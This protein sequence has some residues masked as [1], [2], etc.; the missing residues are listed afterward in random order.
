MIQPLFENFKT[1]EGEHVHRRLDDGTETRS[2][3][4]PSGLFRQRVFNA[5]GELMSESY[6]HGIAILLD[7]KFKAGRKLSETY[8]VR[9]R[10]ASRRGYE[11]ARQDFPDMPP[12]D[13]SLVDDNAE[14]LRDLRLERKQRARAKVRHQADPLQAEKLDRFCQELLASKTGE[15]C[16]AWPGHGRFSFGEMSPAA[17]RRLLADLLALGCTAVTAIDI[18]QPEPGFR[19]AGELVIELPAAAGSR[20]RLF[21]RLGRYA[22]QRGFE[23]YMDHGQRYYFVKF[24]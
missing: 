24:D 8:I 9:R 14:L 17:S 22:V 19:T 3:E 6:S 16:L 20:A 15:D 18:E 11:K 21:K 10:L 1:P 4:F 23:P 12:P 7:A 5:G 13:T 2:M